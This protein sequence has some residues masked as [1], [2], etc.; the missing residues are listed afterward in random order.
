VC[1]RHSLEN[2]V[3]SGSGWFCRGHASEDVLALKFSPI[4]HQATAAES[5]VAAVHALANMIVELAHKNGSAGRLRFRGRR[6]APNHGRPR[7]RRGYQ[8]P[9]SGSGGEPASSSQNEA[10]LNLSGLVAVVPSC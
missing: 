4:F 9:F 6:R 7:E 10:T 2:G 5:V 8:Q 1:D 3:L